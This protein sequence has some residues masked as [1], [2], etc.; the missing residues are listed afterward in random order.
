MKGISGM[1]TKES[2]RISAG[3]EDRIATSPNWSRMITQYQQ[4]SFQ[5]KKQKKKIP[6]SS[7]CYGAMGSLASLQH[8]DEGLIPSPHS[9]LKDPTL[10]QL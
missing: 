6:A 3:S 8:Q 1:T 9:G 5:V 10:P 2:S 4:G 7:S